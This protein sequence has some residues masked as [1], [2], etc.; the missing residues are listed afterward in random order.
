MLQSLSNQNSCLAD[1]AANLPKLNG[2]LVTC[3]ATGGLSSPQLQ[4]FVVGL[5]GG[6]PQEL[7]PLQVT[8]DA[9]HNL[10]P[11]SGKLHGI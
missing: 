3:S 4:S 5:L 8:A 9:Q 10:K 11:S 7:R 6:P 2:L 1:F